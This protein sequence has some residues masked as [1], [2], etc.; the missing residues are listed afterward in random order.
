MIQVVI[1]M[2]EQSSPV[3]M[4][5]TTEIT[6][7]SKEHVAS[8]TKTLDAPPAPRL[9]TQP[10]ALTTGRKQVQRDFLGKAQ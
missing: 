7:R 2:L 9:L 1:Q 6:Q 8:L 10:G 4:T 5:I 3:A